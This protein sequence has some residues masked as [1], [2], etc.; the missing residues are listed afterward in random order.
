MSLN[1]NNLDEPRLVTESGLAARI[2]GLAKPVARSLGFRLVRVRQSGPAMQVMAE[3]ADGSFSIDDC[4]KLSRALSPVLD[5]EDPIAGSYQLEVSSPGIDR[6]LTRASDFARAVGYEAKIEFTQMLN[7]RKRARGVIVSANENGITLAIE[8][9]TENLVVPFNAIAD[10]KLLLNDKLLK[11]AQMRA[12][13]GLSDG[14]PYDPAQH[15][16]IT[17]SED[18]RTSHGR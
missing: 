14:A 4:E 8:G 9:E 1:E 5:A 2:A 3:R 6:P 18:R 7:N 13:S 11:E 15:N 12:K 17:M 10:A 16:N